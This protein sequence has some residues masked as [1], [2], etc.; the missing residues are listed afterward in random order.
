MLSTRYRGRQAA[1]AVRGSLK[2][3]A[4]LPSA[5]ML[6]NPG[7]PVFLE[8]GR[9]Q[10]EKADRAASLPLKLSPEMWSLPDYSM[11]L[12]NYSQYF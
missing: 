1:P 6:R 2:G 9:N 5:A 12:R 8:P 10:A 7:T 11:I 4:F 3:E